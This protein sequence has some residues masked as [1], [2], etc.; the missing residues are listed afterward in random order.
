MLENPTSVSGYFNAVERALKGLA[1]VAETERG[2][3]LRSGLLYNELSWQLSRLEHAFACWKLR[4]LFSDSFKID[5]SESGFP[6]YQAVLQLERDTARREEVLIDIPAADEIRDHM[7]ELLLKY[8][9]FPGELQRT[10]ARREYFE[11]LGEADVFTAFNPPRTLK[12]SIDPKSGRPRYG[13][14]W[15]TYDGS[16]NLPIVY[17]LVVEDSTPVPRPRRLRD[18][19]TRTVIGWRS[20]ISTAFRTSNCVPSSVSLQRTIRATV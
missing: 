18:P 3:K 17:T 1:L 4:C 8:K 19:G 20:C 5:R 11:T 6:P 7:I 15:S 2:N 12:H 13:V 9:Q 16:A 10:M 14:S